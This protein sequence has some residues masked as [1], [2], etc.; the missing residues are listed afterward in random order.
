MFDENHVNGR[1]KSSKLF[2]YP[3]DHLQRDPLADAIGTYTDKDPEEASSAVH[4]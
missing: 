1:K 2:V 4:M 3:E